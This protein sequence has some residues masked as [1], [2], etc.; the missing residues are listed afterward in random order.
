MYHITVH[1]KIGTLPRHNLNM[2][3]LG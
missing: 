3:Q 1:Q 2:W